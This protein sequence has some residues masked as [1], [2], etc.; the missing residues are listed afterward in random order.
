MGQELIIPFTAEELAAYNATGQAA[1]PAATTA[2]EEATEET[3]EE[4][5]A[6]TSVA[7]ADSEEAA[8]AEPEEEEAEPTPA[9]QTAA[10]PVSGRIVYP[11]FSPNI[12]S[13][14]VWMVDLATGEQTPIAGNASQPAFNRDGSLLAYRSWERSTRGIFFRDFIG[15]RGGIVTRFVEDGLPA[16]A[17]DGYSF[18]FTSRK[19][20]DRVPRVYAG[21]Q[22][23]ENPVAIGF[24]GEYPS[25]FPDGR[26]VA[27]G[28][29][30]SG[31]CGMFVMG[32]RGGGE[33]KISGEPADT[34]PAVSPDGSKIAFMSSGRGARNWE[35]WVMD[36]DGS[37]SS[38]I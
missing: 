21:N 15:G 29:L 23:G 8:A 20:G 7:S 27:K 33:K 34:A 26:V 25:T 2:E 31:D 30:P 6:D 4:G 17:P 18:V 11:A 13:Y 28:C 16:W 5:E 24:Q 32:A 38:L 12:N 1:S 3:A 10:A 36:A 35:I 37:N 14:D 19:E 9:P 22:Q